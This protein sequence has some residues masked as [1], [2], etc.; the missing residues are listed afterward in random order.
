MNE[1]ELLRA[2]GGIS[3][4]LILEASGAVKKVRPVRLTA[5]VLAAALVVLTSLTVLAAGMKLSRRSSHSYHKPQYTSLPSAETLMRDVGI[6]PRLPERFSNG[7]AFLQGSIVQNEDYVEDGI[8]FES[9]QSFGCHYEKDGEHVSLYVDAAAAGSQMESDETAAVY[10]GSE[11]KYTA[12]LNKL[13]PPDYQLTEQEKEGCDY[14]ISYG[15]AEIE[16]CRV[17]LLGWEYEGLNYDLCAVDSSLDEDALVQ[18][19]KEIIDLQ[20]DT[21]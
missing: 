9:Y 1:K 3:D 15:S 14:V 2:V 19:A 18:M 20:G 10:R 5:L 17:Q 8:L 4:D 6:A 7:Y 21:K 13:V 16:F 11:I 12:Y